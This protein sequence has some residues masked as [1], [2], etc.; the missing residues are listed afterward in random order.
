MTRPPNSPWSALVDACSTTLG[1]WLTFC[2]AVCLP[3]LVT[4]LFSGVGLFSALPLVVV[5]SMLTGWGLLIYPALLL[6]GILYV[7]F[8][9]SRWLLLLPATVS[10]LDLWRVSHAFRK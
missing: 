10:A 8:E 1:R 5:G 3:Y 7:R 2:L 9:P 6:G 4:G